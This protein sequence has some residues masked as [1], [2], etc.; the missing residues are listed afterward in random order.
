MVGL[1]CNMCRFLVLFLLDLYLG[2]NGCCGD[3][4]VDFLNNYWVDM[5]YFVGDVFDVWCFFGVNWC[6][7]YYEVLWILMSCV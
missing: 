6:I 4:L 5:I 7:E 1:D 2:V 3:W